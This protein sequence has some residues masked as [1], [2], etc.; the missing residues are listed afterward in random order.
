MNFIAVS[1]VVFVAFIIALSM[2]LLS[3]LFGP[4]VKSKTKLENFECGM[5]QADK[6]K[7]FLHVNFYLIA[8]LFLVFD[9]EIIYVYPWAVGFKEL[10]NTAFVSGLFF[11]FVLFI[12][13]YYVIKRRMLKWD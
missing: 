8:V 1:L 6:P 3:Y 9:I 13:V 11:I 7:K 5:P 2:I 12:A 10:S 4:K